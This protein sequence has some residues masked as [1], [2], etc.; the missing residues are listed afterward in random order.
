MDDQRETVDDESGLSD[1]PTARLHPASMPALALQR[2]AGD[3]LAQVFGAD[4]SA[5]PTG[6]SDGG[7]STYLGQPSNANQAAN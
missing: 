7:L 2:D 3:P 1:Q 5:V 6:Q 4:A